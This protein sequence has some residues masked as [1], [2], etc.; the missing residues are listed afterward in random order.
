MVKT[1]VTKELIESLL[2]L[3]PKDAD[4]IIHRPIGDMVNRMNS[5]IQYDT[6]EGA[7]RIYSDNRRVFRSHESG[8]I[9]RFARGSP[10]AWVIL[11]DSQ[12]IVKKPDLCKFNTPIYVYELVDQ[13]VFTPEDFRVPR[14]Y[15]GDDLTG[16]SIKRRDEYTKIRSRV[17][18]AFREWPECKYGGQPDIYFPTNTATVFCVHCHTI[19]LKSS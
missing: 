1:E 8:C 7:Y 17:K 2:D 13:K 11:K 4:F 12:Q 14:G 9:R 3:V 18:R 10:I 5:V 15:E 19:K 6:A 16:Q